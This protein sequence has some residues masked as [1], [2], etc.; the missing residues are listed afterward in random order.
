LAVSSFDP[1]ELEQLL[2]P[3]VD[4]AEIRFELPV[5]AVKVR[6]LALALR[7]QNPLC[8]DE[9]AAR[10]AGFAGLVAPPTFP[11]MQAWE[12][13]VDQLQQLGRRV[14]YDRAL[15]AEQTFVYARP[16]VAG[17]VLSGRC[18]LAAVRSGSGRSGEMTFVTY[19]T[20]YRDGERRFVAGSDYTVVE[21]G[22]GRPGPTAQAERPEPPPAQWALDL[23]PVGRADFARYAGAS[24]DFHP[25]HVDE[26]AALAVGEPSVFA[27]GMMSAGF[28]ASAATS[29]AE[30]PATLERFSTRIVARVWPGDAL[31]CEGNAAGGPDEIELRLRRRPPG[32]EWQTAVVG[33][34]T[35][36]RT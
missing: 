35:Y 10:R 2:R 15:H 19:R 20:D 12:V 18:H 32:G 14:D 16:L 29:W 23:E 36:S 33:A 24:G 25:M 13:A 3:T 6:E 26:A 31:R 8:R 17:E 21:L 27:A 7:D 9:A 34:A 30:A 1:V 11:V 28:L 22:Q 5:T 4:E